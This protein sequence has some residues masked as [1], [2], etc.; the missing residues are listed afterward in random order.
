[1]IYPSRNCPT[2]HAGR[3]S[4]W[5]WSLSGSIISLALLFLAADCCISA[6]TPSLSLPPPPDA[7]ET[8]KAKSHPGSEAG[9]RSP[10]E[11]GD[12]VG[13]SEAEA[14][15]ARQALHDPM[16]RYLAPPGPGR[17][18]YEIIIN[19][20]SFQLILYKDGVRY[21]TY[22][23]AVGKV[24]SPSIL[25]TVHIIN[26]VADPTYYPPDWYKRNLKPISPG[27]DNPV[28]TR[29]LGLSVKGYGIHGTNDPD[30]IGGARSAGCV[31]MHNADVE[32]LSRLIP[33]GTPVTFVYDLL[34]TWLDVATGLAMLQAYPDVYQLGRPT[35]A[36]WE[37]RWRE[38]EIGASLHDDALRRIL[39]LASG[40]PEPAP[41]TEPIHVEGLGVGPGYRVG[42]SHYVSLPQLARLLGEAHAYTG[43]TTVFG[44]HVPGAWSWEGAAYAPVEAAAEAFGLLW[45]PERRTLQPVYLN[46]QEKVLLRLFVQ[47]GDV[48]VPITQLVE[49]LTAQFPGIAN[50][51]ADDGL[52]M[53]GMRIIAGQVFCGRT[54]IERMLGVRIDWGPG[55]GQAWLELASSQPTSDA[56]PVEAQLRYD[57][58][59]EIR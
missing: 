11:A 34:T 23:I 30:S 25:G 40:Q 28:G 8:Q 35:P 57:S 24:V 9:P 54:D 42:D 21:R 1:M 46:Y 12:L 29:W 59:H 20:P 19:I 48:L 51:M 31:R 6:P 22:P 47:G 26:K 16:A 52:S 37:E 10:A 32:E 15:Q 41:L 43:D 45:R 7:W 3:L 33:V 17:P 4:R 2:A 36:Q 44:Y 58:E 13:S 5:Q 39:A 18:T 14:S 56:P 50:A 27:P 49:A 38:L 53:S 55:S